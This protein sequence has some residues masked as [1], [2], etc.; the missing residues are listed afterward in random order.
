MRPFGEVAVSPFKVRHTA[1]ELS[2]LSKLLKSL[3]GETRVVLES[4][5]KYPWLLVGGLPGYPPLLFL[6]RPRLPP[7]FV[8]LHDRLR[9]H[10]EV[11]QAPAQLVPIRC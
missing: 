7:A 5:G 6:L 9:L 1:S 11:P 4:T 2:E 3:D 10:P 8:L